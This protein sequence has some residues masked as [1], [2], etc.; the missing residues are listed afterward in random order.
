MRTNESAASGHVTPCSP[1]IGCSW[2]NYLTVQRVARVASLLLVLPLLSSVLRVPDIIII[3]GEKFETHFIV[4]SI[5][6]CC[7]LWTKKD[8]NRL[9][10]TSRSGHS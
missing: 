10:L 8:C 5:F 3:I 2:A 6:V 4:K 1:L 9:G 7:F